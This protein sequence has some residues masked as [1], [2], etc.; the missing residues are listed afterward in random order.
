MRLLPVG[1]AGFEP[2]TSPTRTV[3]ATKLRHAPKLCPS[4]QAHKIIND[5]SR[6]AKRRNALFMVA[7]SSSGEEGA[8]GSFEADLPFQ[9]G[10][11]V[12]AGPTIHQRPGVAPFMIEDVHQ[13]SALFQEAGR[14]EIACHL[15]AV[16]AEANQLG[17][18]AA[19]APRQAYVA[20]AR[21]AVEAGA[22]G[23]GVDDEGG[24]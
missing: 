11:F 24:A 5:E 9:D 21:I 22:D 13:R 7:A 3:R 1:A 8:D 20:R 18:P 6:F 4:E 12:P 10:R 16:I 15:H 2:T 23:A 19:A 14:P 17:T